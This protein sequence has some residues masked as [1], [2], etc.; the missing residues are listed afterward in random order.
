MLHDIKVPATLV[1][2]MEGIWGLTIVSFI[3]MPIAAV[4]PGEEGGGVHENTLD[5]LVMI[6]NNLVI[7]GLLLGYVFSILVLNM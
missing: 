5:S 1:V 7:L 3:A 6:S 2:G 4:L